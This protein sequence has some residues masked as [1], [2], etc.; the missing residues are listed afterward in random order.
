MKLFGLCTFLHDES[1]KNFL[2]IS[3]V[4]DLVK[5]SPS[6]FSISNSYFAGESDSFLSFFALELYEVTFY[7]SPSFYCN[8]GFVFFLS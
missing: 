7:K 3:T 6:W 1:L 4:M 8:C 2:A 5:F